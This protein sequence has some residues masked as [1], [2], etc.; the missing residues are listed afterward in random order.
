ME[1]L[2]LLAYVLSPILG[3]AFAWFVGSAIERA[4]LQDIVKREQQTATLPAI[5]LKHLPPEWTVDGASPTPSSLVM[6]SVVVSIDHFKRFLAGWRMIVGGRVHSIE[7]LMI[8]GRREAL[9]RL[10]ENASRDGYDALM[11][12]RF[13]TS[14]VAS[15]LS[16]RN[17]V[18]GVEVFAFGT[19][20][21]RSA[22]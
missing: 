16:K 14:T 22:G 8:R 18:A 19:G 10:K 13:E 7:T 3:L 2:A 12:V 9:L 17:G 20:L 21:K 1:A 11:N 6:G 5:T 4:H 15:N